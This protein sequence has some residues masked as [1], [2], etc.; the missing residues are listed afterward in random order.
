MYRSCSVN[1]CS[2]LF[3]TCCTAKQ[4]KSI[5]AK[6][7]IFI[8]C[9]SAVSAEFVF[10]F[11]FKMEKRPQQ[12]FAYTL[13]HTRI[14]WANGCTQT[15]SQTCIHCCTNKTIQEFNTFTTI[16]DNFLKRRNFTHIFVVFYCLVSHIR[17]VTCFVSLDFFLLP[18]SFTRSVFSCSRSRKSFAV[19]LCTISTNVF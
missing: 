17:T 7:E 6:M 9:T 10:F 15:H 14:H 4:N 5:N 8:F 16:F 19:C 13:K 1:F 11:R 18:L 3:W 2:F 12:S